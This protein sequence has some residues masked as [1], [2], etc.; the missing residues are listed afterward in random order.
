MFPVAS[1]MNPLFGT[2]GVITTGVPTVLV[3]LSRR[4]IACRGLSICTPHP[5]P[6]HPHPPNPIA[7]LC[8]ETVRTL[9]MQPVAHAGS[10]LACLHPLAVYPPNVTVLVGG[11]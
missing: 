7:T 6:G 4:P 8:T 11:I 10:L 9:G 3:G 2:V 5:A 1:V